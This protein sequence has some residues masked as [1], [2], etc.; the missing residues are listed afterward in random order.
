MEMNIYAGIFLAELN[1][2]YGTNAS[3]L[4]P[5]PI[6]TLMMLFGLFLAS[7]PDENPRWILWSRAID[8]V[9]RSLV[10]NGGEVNRYVV[11]LGTTIFI[12]GVFFSRYARRLLAHPFMNFLGRISF[13]IYLLHNTLIRTA[14]S[15]VLYRQSIMTK[16]LHPVDKEG[17][18]IFYEQSG[19]FTFAV[20]M[21]L[22][23]LTL[24]Y[25]SHLWTVH[26]DPRC[27]KV[28]SWLSKA[29]GDTNTFESLKEHS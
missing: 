14:L 8:A 17:K 24:V 19:A 5:W 18:P 1:T 23:Y 13:P 4:I 12:F 7:F 27:E 15:W 22:F 10:P 2:D 20:A 9:G 11:S 26:V 16:G 25:V 21:P 3:S 6:S 29:F 28:V